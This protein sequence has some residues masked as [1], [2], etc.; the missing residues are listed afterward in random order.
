MFAVINA[1]ENT[2]PDN[3]SASDVAGWAGDLCSFVQEIVNAGVTGD[4][5]TTYA[6]Q[7]FNSNNST[8]GNLDLIADLDAVNI[9]QA[10]RNSQNLTFAEVFKNYYFSF[11]V[12]KIF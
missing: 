10:Y 12:L 6:T 9:M 3:F 5:I 4:D 1:I 2:E 8:F 7:N 11:S